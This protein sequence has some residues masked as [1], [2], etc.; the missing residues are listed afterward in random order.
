MR[1]APPRA[2]H[3]A[4]GQ[5]ESM[6]SPVAELSSTGLGVDQPKTLKGPI[7]QLLSLLEDGVCLLSNVKLLSPNN[8]KL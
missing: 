6:A 1:A 3:R 4:R 2:P 7:F 8:L 5:A